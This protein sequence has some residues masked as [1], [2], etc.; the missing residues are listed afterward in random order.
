MLQVAVVG[1]RARGQDESAVADSVAEGVAGSRAAHTAAVVGSRLTRPTSLE[2]SHSHLAV[3]Q[4]LRVVLAAHTAAL[5]QTW[6]WLGLAA[7]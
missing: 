2:V 1:H 3:H 6:C 4:A 7:A 5:R